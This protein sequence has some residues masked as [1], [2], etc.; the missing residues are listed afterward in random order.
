MLSSLARFCVRRRR[1]VVFGIWIPLFFIVAVVSGAMK[2]N[3]RTDFV[4]PKSESRE[5]QELLEKANP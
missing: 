2:G 4:L 3:F 5:V 1:I